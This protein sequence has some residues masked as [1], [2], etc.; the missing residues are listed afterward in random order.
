MFHSCLE[1]LRLLDHFNGN[2]KL[3]FALPGEVHITKLA[4]AEWSSNFKILEAPLPTPVVQ[5]LWWFVSE[6]S[7]G[8]NKLGSFTSSRFRQQLKPL[9]VVHFLS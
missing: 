7:R 6:V 2:N 3:A 9:S 4:A 1:Q 8:I 5:D